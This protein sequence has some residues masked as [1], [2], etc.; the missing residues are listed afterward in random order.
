MT[1]WLAQREEF[2][3][4]YRSHLRQWD[5]L[6]ALVD[7]VPAFPHTDTPW[8]ERML[9]VNGLSVAFDIQTAYPAVATLSDQPATAFPVGVHNS[10]LRIGLQAIGPYLEDR[11]PIRFAG[12]V[13]QDFGGF[14]QPPAYGL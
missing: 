4:S 11:T 5:V 13:A 14:A 7:I 2:R 9:D 3:Q 6:L 8:A 1:G 12:L 10:G